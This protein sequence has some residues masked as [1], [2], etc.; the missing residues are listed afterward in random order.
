MMLFLAILSITNFLDW[1]ESGGFFLVIGL[2]IIFAVA[3]YLAFQEGKR[4][5][6]K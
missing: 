1:F 2:P 6:D 4:R 5:G 3:C